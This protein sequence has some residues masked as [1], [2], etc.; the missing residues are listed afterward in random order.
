MD[1]TKQSKRPQLRE[2]RSKASLNQS[3]IRKSF[4]KKQVESAVEKARQAGL[5]TDERQSPT[6]EEERKLFFRSSV[7]FYQSMR[8]VVLSI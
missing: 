6:N 5:K 2:M 8:L 4:M 1:R 3:K 7:F